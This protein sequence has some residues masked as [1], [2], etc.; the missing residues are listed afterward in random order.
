MNK[1]FST[2]SLMFKQAHNWVVEKEGGLDMTLQA[3]KR[4]PALAGDFINFISQFSSL[5]NQPIDRVYK[6]EFKKL[7][8]EPHDYISVINDIFPYLC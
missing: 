7:Y 3:L 5:M 8:S 2:N 6:D 4:H 1:E